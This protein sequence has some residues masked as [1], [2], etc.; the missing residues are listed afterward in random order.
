M[1]FL[2]KTCLPSCGR[3]VCHSVSEQFTLVFHA[4]P[5]YPIF[6]EFSVSF[7]T[8]FFLTLAKFVKAINKTLLIP[9]SLIQLTCLIPICRLFSYLE[10]FRDFCKFPNNASRYYFDFAI[11]IYI[12]YLYSEMYY[13]IYFILS[14]NKKG[15]KTVLPQFVLF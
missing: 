1:Y 10:V 4:R 12:I 14:Q 9:N 5:S 15:L 6:C 7:E 11:V 2:T 13:K 8:P 3:G